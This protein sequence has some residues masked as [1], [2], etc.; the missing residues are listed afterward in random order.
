MGVITRTIIFALGLALDL[1]AASPLS[2]ATTV[3]ELLRECTEGKE[4]ELHCIGY[5][6]GIGEV[7]QLMGASIGFGIC[8][9]GPISHGAMQQHSRN[10]Q[11]TPQNWG[12]RARLG[13]MLALRETW[14]CK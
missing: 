14:P 9:T 12:D 2:R 3:Q 5:V 1:A 10:G 7:M 4:L 13:V 8:S 6:G 11:E